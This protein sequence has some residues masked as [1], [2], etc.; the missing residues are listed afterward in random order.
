MPGSWGPYLDSNT[1]ANGAG[2]YK[3]TIK[4]PIDELYAI[5]TRTIR[6]SNRIFINGEEVIKV[7]NPSLQRDG[8]ILESKHEI[9]AGR[10]NNSVIELMAHVSN[11]DYNSGGIVRFI[12]FGTF[13][14]I[15]KENNK[16]RA[17]DLLPI[18]VCIT[19]GLYFLIIYFQRSKEK[20]MRYFSFLNFSLALNNISLFNPA[21]S[22]T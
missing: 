4:L 9:G 19:L 2:T 20:Y 10:S 15:M 17:T 18:A 16:D 3:L 5:K 1:L 21:S 8:F 11:Y 22:A 6:S 13:D 14:N 7:G 12:E